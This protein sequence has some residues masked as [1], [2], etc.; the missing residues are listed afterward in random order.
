MNGYETLADNE[1][2]MI[3]VAGLSKSIEILED[4]ILRHVDNSELSS[5]HE[6]L[7][8]NRVKERKNTANNP[9]AVYLRPSDGSH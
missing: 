9:I 6:R 2:Y 7:V 5:H 1:I 4:F 3:T 8:L